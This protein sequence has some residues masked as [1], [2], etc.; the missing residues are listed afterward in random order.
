MPYPWSRGIALDLA[1][2]YIRNGKPWPVRVG[3]D[4]RR[5]RTGRCYRLHLVRKK[6][7]LL[8][9]YLEREGKPLAKK[10]NVA[11][12]HIVKAGFPLVRDNR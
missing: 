10:K 3:V 6:S 5:K 11:E 7:G 4:Y 1:L 9:L 2:A 8:T 12:H